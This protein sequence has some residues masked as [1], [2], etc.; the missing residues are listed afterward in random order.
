MLPGISGAAAPFLLCLDSFLP[1]G[2][3]ADCPEPGLLP[4][5][6]LTGRLSYWFGGIYG[7]K[8]PY[9][10]AQAVF[11]ALWIPSLQRYCVLRPFV[12]PALGFVWGAAAWCVL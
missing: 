3:R 5:L 12:V 8:N 11:V 7:C 4:G 9:C 6:C 10:C 1:F 2:G